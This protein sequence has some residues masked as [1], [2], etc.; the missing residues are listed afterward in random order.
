MMIQMCS[1]HDANCCFQYKL[2]LNKQTSDTQHVLA[3]LHLGERG[4]LCMFHSW[5]NH[6]FNLAV[7][8]LLIRSTHR[9]KRELLIFGECE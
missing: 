9:S 5:P 8:R 6:R 1:L 4:Q 3:K 7:K 2:S